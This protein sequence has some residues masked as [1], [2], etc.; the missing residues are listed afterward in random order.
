MRRD[1]HLKQSRYLS[2]TTALNGRD[3]EDDARGWQ[4]RLCGHSCKAV[5]DGNWGGICQLGKVRHKVVI[6]VI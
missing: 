4:V 3:G 2:Y 1:L 6:L 5:G